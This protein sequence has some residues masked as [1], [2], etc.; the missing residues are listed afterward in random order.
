MRA[1]LIIPALCGVLLTYNTGLNNAVV[2]KFT[3]FICESYNTSW[4]VFHNCRLKAV[5][6]NK[7]LLNMN[8]TILHPAY[9]IH[10]HIQ[11]LKRANGYK[12]WLFDQ[13]LDVC[14]FIRYRSNPFATLV[15]GLFKEFSN[16]NHT[17]PYMGTQIVKDFYLKYELLRLPLPTGDYMLTMGWFLDRKLQFDTNVSFTFVED[18]LKKN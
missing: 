10:L 8:G 16:F 7:V 3:N 12:P 9:D 11:V 15:F 1:L 4:F 17:C 5:S 13:K 18:I 6:R 14:Q 2:F